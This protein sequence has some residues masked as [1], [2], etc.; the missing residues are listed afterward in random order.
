MP[1]P[2]RIEA[3]RHVICHCAVVVQPVLVGGVQLVYL[4]VLA[5]GSAASVVAF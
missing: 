3:V 1:I 4:N 2:F 5:N